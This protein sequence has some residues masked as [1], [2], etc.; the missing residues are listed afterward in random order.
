M[1][2]S[3]NILFLTDLKGIKIRFFEVLR[4]Q[5]YEPM[6]NNYYTINT[7][8]YTVVTSHQFIITL[9]NNNRKICILG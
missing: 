1:S 2:H 3:E 8:I 5:M 6:H 4:N 7:K 9:I